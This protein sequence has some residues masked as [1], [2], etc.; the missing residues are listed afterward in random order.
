[1]GVASNVG[2]GNSFSNSRTFEATPLSN[3][4]NSPLKSTFTHFEGAGQRDDV[5][6]A[7]AFELTERDGLLVRDEHYHRTEIVIGI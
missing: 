2:T 1:M 3:S 7:V 4:R 6:G 5:T